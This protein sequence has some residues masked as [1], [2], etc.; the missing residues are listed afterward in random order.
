MIRNVLH[1]GLGQVATTILTIV[2]SATMARMLG[3]SDFGTWYLL[4]SIATFAYVIVDWGHGPFITR[5]TARHPDR[6]GVLLGSALAV[7]TAAALFVCPFAVATTWLLGYDMS[8]RVLT[9]AMILC[10]LP[11]YLGLSF[12]WVFR[13]YERMD[14]DAVLNVV[15]KLA[16]LI[17]SVACLMLGGRLLGLV[18]ASSVAGCLTLAMGIA[19]YR[20]LHLPPISATV[21]TARELLRDGAPML[22]MSLA[23]AIEPYF[24][25]NILY[26]MASPEVVGWYGA[27]WNI[28]G[29]LIAPATILGATMYPRLSTAAGDRSHFKRVFDVSF[30]PLLLVAVL[31]AVG[32]YLFADVA[33]GLIYSLQKFGPA[34]DTLRA[35]AP[36]VLLM[37]VDLFFATAILSAGKAG[38]LAST[39][40]AV[41]VI[42]TALVFVL[43]PICQARFANGGIGVM[44]ALATG[45]LLMVAA[46]FII[47]RDVADRR[48]IGDVCRSLIAGF[49]TILLIR[50][51]PALNPF[52][53]IPLCVLAFGGLS[54][55]VG[56]AKR[57][58]VE[59][60]LSA[61]RK[62]PPVPVPTGDGVPSVPPL[63][64]N[65]KVE[66]SSDPAR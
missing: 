43:V 32:T 7:R 3:P 20:R 22:A 12:G 17:A 62:K 6:S 21:P 47:L 60:L 26:K 52:L 5:E 51:L 38:R 33:V 49:A 53:A 63:I 54:L 37:Y 15:F 64:L 25:S 55:L 27:A 4:T 41:V 57:S 42:T 45:E 29:T 46:A 34:A 56:A 44:F 66:S 28:A 30:R 1:L 2:L 40:V 19:M 13:A 48:T 61:F 8:A 59:M 9:A 58:D 31:G 36:V 10:L 50:L 16:M 65:A 11:Q 14:R 24:N 39:K 35:F 18:L 23:V